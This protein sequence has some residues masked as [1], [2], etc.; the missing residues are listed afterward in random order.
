MI[1]SLLELEGKNYKLTKD[2]LS[3]LS[4]LELQTAFHSDLPIQELGKRLKLSSTRNKDERRVSHAC[5]LPPLICTENDFKAFTLTEEK[6]NY[7][8]SHRS[9]AQVIH[10]DNS[11]QQGINVEGCIVMIPQADPGY[12]WLFGQ[13]IAGLITK[14]GGANSHMAIRSAE[15]GLAAAIGVG[16]QIFTSL[17]RA[18][19]IELDP[20]G[21]T[22]R[23]IH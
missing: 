21:E 17:S 3:N 9:T 14:Y 12:D 20:V 22:I 16:E 10:I 19:T 5:L 11:G 8:G 4:L 7:I 23:A 6:P 18:K 1:L 13:K 2:E 15:F